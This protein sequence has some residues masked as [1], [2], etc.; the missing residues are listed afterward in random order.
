MYPEFVMGLKFVTGQIFI[1][2]LGSVLSVLSTGYSSFHIT[3]VVFL[4]LEF[5]N[6][7]TFVL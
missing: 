4:L 1:I 7:R 6:L 2:S 5:I 3:L